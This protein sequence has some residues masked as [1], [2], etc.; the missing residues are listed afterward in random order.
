M[1]ASWGKTETNAEEMKSIAVHDEVPKEETAIETSGTQ[2][3]RHGD[4][5]LAVSRRG[6]SKNRTQGHGGSW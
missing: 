1:E 2:K 4:R 3:K 5:H 6:R